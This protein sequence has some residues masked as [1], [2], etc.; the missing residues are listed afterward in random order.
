MKTCVWTPMSHKHFISEKSNMGLADFSHICQREIY[1]GG[2][3]RKKNCEV[4]Q[5]FGQQT[6]GQNNRSSHLFR[7]CHVCCSSALNI[8]PI[9][10][11]LRP[12]LFHLVETWEASIGYLP[13]TTCF[14][15]KHSLSRALSR[16][17]S[18]QDKC[19]D[20]WFSCLT[21]VAYGSQPAAIH[22]QQHARIT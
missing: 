22:P 9:S 1:L 11:S 4:L 13:K 3:I 21:W 16:V 17:A 5:D 7:A 12:C 8:L 14:L 19:S 2:F 6:A 15:K 10:S 18:P 20:S